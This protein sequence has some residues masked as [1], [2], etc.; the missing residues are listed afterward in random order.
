MINKYLKCKAIFSFQAVYIVADYKWS[1]RNIDPESE[2][3]AKIK[4]QVRTSHVLPSP[5]FLKKNEDFIPMFLASLS[6]S[7]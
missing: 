6:F 1:L 2:D 7:M 5:K 3:Y 4:S